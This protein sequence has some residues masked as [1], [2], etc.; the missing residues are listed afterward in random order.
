MYNNN[1]THKDADSHTHVISMSHR[2]KRARRLSPQR[3]C[4]VPP[5]RLGSP[6]FSL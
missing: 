2:I 1:K 4:C 3:P 6:I 5:A